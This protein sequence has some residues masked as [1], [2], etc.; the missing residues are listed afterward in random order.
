VAANTLHKIQ[1]APDER[2]PLTPFPA[3]AKRPSNASF[4]TKHLPPVAFP[5]LLSFTQ[6]RR[7]N[8]ILREK[9]PDSLFFSPSCNELAVKCCAF[10][11][12]QIPGGAV[13]AASLCRG[14]ATL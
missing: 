4:E 8:A 1:R 9:S 2:I 7:M 5:E 14:A 13:V 12:I 11:A 10:A 6:S 3:R